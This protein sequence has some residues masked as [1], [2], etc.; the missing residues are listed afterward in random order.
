MDQDGPDIRSGKYRRPAEERTH[1]RI[2]MLAVLDDLPPELRR[3]VELLQC[4]SATQAAREMG[5]PRRTFREK[6][7]VQL[8]EIFKAKG[9]DQYLS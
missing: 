4:M 6:H 8:S 5:I 1:L 7:L 9:L 2:D 3:A